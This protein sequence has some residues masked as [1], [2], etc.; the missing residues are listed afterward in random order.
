MGSELSNREKMAVALELV[1]VGDANAVN[2]DM[3]K[4]D[5]AY[6]KLLRYQAEA[7]VV[8]R[9]A[10]TGRRPDGSLL[11]SLP[12]SYIPGGSLG[13]ANISLR[14]VS[15]GRA[16]SEPLV[17]KVQSEEHLSA[18]LRQLP[19]RIDIGHLFWSACP[20][21][22]NREVDANSV[23]PG[24]LWPLASRL[25]VEPESLEGKSFVYALEGNSYRLKTELLVEPS[26]PEPKPLSFLEQFD[27]M[28]ANTLQ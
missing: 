21:D 1:R 27:K 24:A 15:P 25:G 7:K 11:G 5:E 2:L 20:L 18:A 9:D 3:G 17:L 8:L 4:A 22:P 23:R 19:D 10:A 14:A 28:R 13:P 6:R 12:Q 26:K 16:P